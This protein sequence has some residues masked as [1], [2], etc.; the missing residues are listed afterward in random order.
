[1]IVPEKQKKTGFFSL[2]QHAAFVSVSCVWCWQGSYTETRRF[3]QRT[4]ERGREKVCWW[5]KVGKK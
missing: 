5:K 2:P 1:M 4:V 3:D